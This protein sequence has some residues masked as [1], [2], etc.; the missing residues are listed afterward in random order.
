M[1]MYRVGPAGIPASL[2]ADM[3]SVLNKKFSTS[4]TYPPADWP[5]TINLMGPLP[6][7]T[8]SGAIAHIEDGASEVPVKNWL[9]TLPASLSGYSEVNGTKSG[10]NFYPIKIGADRFSNNSDATHTNND[11]TLVIS[12]AAKNN[13]G[14]YINTNDTLCEI[15]NTLKWFNDNSYPRIISLDVKCSVDN[16]T[17][18]ITSGTRYTFTMGTT[19]TRVS[20]VST[21]A[22][23]SMYVQGAD[24]GQS[25]TFEISNFQIEY[26]TTS[27]D[28][29]PYT[30][31]TQYTASLGRTVYGGTADIVN[32][33]GT[34]QYA[35]VDLGSLTWTKVTSGQAPYFASSALNPAY[36]YVNNNPNA[37]CSDYTQ[38]SIGGSGTA[39]GFFI[40]DGSSVRIRDDN[41]AS[42]TGTEFKA[43]MSGKYLTYELATPTD[44]TFT[45]ITP[46]PETENVCNFWADE[47][48]SEVTYRAD[49]DLLL[50]NL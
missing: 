40:T 30:A 13:S 37:I 21:G 24:L 5:D 39:N 20:L 50:N 44:F 4:T 29:E 7:R 26:G 16:A 12:A 31:P 41:H 18:A 15:R 45:Q 27:T 43:S 49:I 2:K 42:E 32:G 48:D 1:T 3:N 47:G 33:E 8:A 36:K 6:E 28:Y 10:K 9:V 22:N 17:L 14:V 11:G 35:R 23:C 19:K 38:A 46:T 34:E 25:C